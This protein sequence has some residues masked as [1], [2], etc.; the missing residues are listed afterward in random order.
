MLGDFLLSA[1][2]LRGSQYLRGAHHPHCDRHHNHLIW[3]AGHPLCL[4]CTCMYSGILLGALLT[5][6]FNSSMINI[7]TWIAVIVF[8][9]L[10]TLL[11]PRIQVKQFKIVSR[12]MLGIGVSFYLISGLMLV[13]P[14]FD[15]TLFRI[16]LVGIFIVLH[17]FLRTYRNHYTKSPCDNCPLGYFPSCEWNLPRLLAE[18]YDDEFIEALM[19]DK[20]QNMIIK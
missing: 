16:F 19:S 3:I 6:L 12:A 20:L 14:P 15:P 11:Q 5:F 18:N 2:Q 9:L 8:L 17:R 4:G 1:K 13:T 7:S 10:P